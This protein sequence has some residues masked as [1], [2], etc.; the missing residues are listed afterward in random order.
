MLVLSS[1]GELYALSLNFPFGN[2]NLIRITSPIIH[3]VNLL[4]FFFFKLIKKIS[5]K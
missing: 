1:I 2:D 5:M 4:F 3:G